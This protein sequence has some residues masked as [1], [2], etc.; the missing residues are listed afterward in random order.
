[1]YELHHKLNYKILSQLKEIVKPLT[2]SVLTYISL[3]P[4]VSRL[5]NEWYNIFIVIPFVFIYV[6]LNILMKNE[7][8]ILVLKNIRCK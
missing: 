5:E 7:G 4:I 3:Y 8:V 1:M 2:S 6:F